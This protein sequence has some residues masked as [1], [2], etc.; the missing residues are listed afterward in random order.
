MD[1][2]AALQRELRCNVSNR[3]F[4]LVTFAAAMALKSSYCSLAHG[5][6]LRAE[7]SDAE[8]VE[9]AC[10]HYERVVTTAEAAAMR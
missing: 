5:S 10:G 4:E 6:T 1:K 8:I 2:W 9:L 3:L 7:L